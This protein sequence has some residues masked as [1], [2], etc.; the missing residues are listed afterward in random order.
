MES[1][2]SA[3]VLIRFTRAADA[4]RGTRAGFSSAACDD[5]RH[6]YEDFAAPIAAKGFATQTGQFG[7]DMK[8]S[9]INAGPVAI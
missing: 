9:F 5:E 3:L 6:R 4:R 1:G 7:A 2:G 8:A